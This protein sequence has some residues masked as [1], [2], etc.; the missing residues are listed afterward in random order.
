MSRMSFS[1]TTGSL[2]RRPPQEHNG[3]T[4]RGSWLVHP[5]VSTEANLGARPRSIRKKIKDARGI[6]VQ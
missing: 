6:Q 4:A 1:L 5:L 2:L 3:E